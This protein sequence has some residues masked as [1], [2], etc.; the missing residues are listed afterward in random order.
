MSK[1]LI[2]VVCAADGGDGSRRCWGGVD[3][4]AV[5]QPNQMSIDMLID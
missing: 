4:E 1:T 5:F 3:Y 2:Q